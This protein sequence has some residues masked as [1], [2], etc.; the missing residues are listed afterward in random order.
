M[1][2]RQ[3]L[4]TPTLRAA[5]Y[6]EKCIGMITQMKSSSSTGLSTPGLSEFVVSITV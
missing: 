3:R 6:F 2:S 4:V 1:Y 5:V